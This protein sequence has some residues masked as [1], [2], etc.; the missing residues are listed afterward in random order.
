MNQIDRLAEDARD[1]VHA[2][3]LAVLARRR[4][5]EAGV[6]EAFPAM[7]PYRV[8]QAMNAHYE[9]GQDLDRIA[10]IVLSEERIAA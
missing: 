3:E 7:T 2:L 1:A 4:D 5:I 6:A 8:K 9:I 10:A